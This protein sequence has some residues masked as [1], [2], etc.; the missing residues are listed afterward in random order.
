MRIHN[1]KFNIFKLH[2]ILC[3][4]FCLLLSFNNYAKG[5]AKND[6]VEITK[7]DVTT[8]KSFNGAHATVFGI[9]LGMGRSA[10]KQKITNYPYF[11]LKPDG[12]NPRRFYLEDI[13]SDTATISLAY[14]IWTNYDSGL[15]QVILYPA[16]SKYLKGLSSDIVSPSC[17]DVAS[18]IYKYLGEPSARQVTSEIASIKSKTTQLYYPKYSIIIEESQSGDKTLYNLVLTH[19][20]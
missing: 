19:K 18:E 6:S 3:I 12:F 7:T 9:A 16:M 10:A 13:S 2:L 5:G 20:W 14:L 1:I 11:K 8:L 4:S 15:Y 17:I